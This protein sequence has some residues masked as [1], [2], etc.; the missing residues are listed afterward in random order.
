MIFILIFFS[1]IFFIKSVIFNEMYSNQMMFLYFLLEISTFSLN[2]SYLFDS[3]IRWT[4]VGWINNDNDKKYI[5][6]IENSNSLSSNYIII[7]S[8]IISYILYVFYYYI[9]ERKKFTEWE[10]TKYNLKYYL[11]HFFCL[12][13][14]NLNTIFNLNNTMF[15]PSLINVYIFNLI[16][17]WIPGI[18]CNIIYGDKLHLYRKIFN[19]IIHGFNLKYKYYILI[20]ILLKIICGLDIIFKNFYKPLENYSILLV[21]LIYVYLFNY[22]N[23]FKK[24]SFV[25]YNNILSSMSFVIISISTINKYFNIFHLVVIQHILIFTMLFSFIYIIYKLKKEQTVQNNVIDM[26]ELVTVEQ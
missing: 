2:N 4:F 16:T 3:I 18:I 21:L 12:Y 19:F 9:K 8:W 5:G 23:I 14:W 13:T 11:T 26:F 15:L 1:L 6:E 17:F 20:N 25:K 24:K 10:F 22:H 7:I